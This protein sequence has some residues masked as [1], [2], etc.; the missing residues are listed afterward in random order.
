M[1]KSFL[2]R[3]LTRA[4]TS[5]FDRWSARVM[6]GAPVPQT[7]LP[8]ITPV[9]P[10]PPVSEPEPA[11][12]TLR[13][14]AR[15]LGL[16]LKE[17]PQGGFVCTRR[18]HEVWLPPLEDEDFE[19]WRGKR[20]A[21][22]QL[23]AARLHLDALELEYEPQMERAPAPARILR[24]EDV[25]LEHGE[26]LCLLVP[27]DVARDF[28]AFHGEVLWSAQAPDPELC[29][30]YVQEFGTSWHAMTQT[31]AQSHPLGTQKLAH[32]AYRTLFY[33][34]YRVRPSATEVND[35]GKIKR[36]ETTE[37]YGGSRVQLL[38]DFD[39]DALRAGGCAGAPSRHVMLVAHPK[40]EAAR[41][42]MRQAL[43]AEVARVLNKGLWPLSAM[44][45]DLTPHGI[46]PST[47]PAAS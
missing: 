42:A 38:P 13:T 22:S 20:R 29:V 34:S 40:D 9:P 43:R 46:E 31:Q 8:P 23:F 36:T 4:L 11:P 37:G 7:H 47:D 17:A 28:E 27:L 10:Q 16:V 33:Q 26:R 2:A 12:L 39:H 1:P 30:L 24:K 44:C 32:D 18:G 14:W 15:P 45:V 35:H 25:P 41:A 5:A 19:G 6:A 21:W 3:A